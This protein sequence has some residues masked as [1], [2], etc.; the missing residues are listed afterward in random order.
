MFI[1]FLIYCFFNDD[2]TWLLLL[3]YFC[4]FFQVSEIFERLYSCFFVVSISHTGKFRKKIHT[5]PCFPLYF[6]SFFANTRFDLLTFCFLRSCCLQTFCKIYVLKNFCNIQWKTFALDSHLNKVAGLKVCNIV[7]DM[8][9]NTFVTDLAY[10]QPF[11]SCLLI[12]LIIFCFAY[13]FSIP[14]KSVKRN[15]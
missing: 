11:Q 1:T 12:E 4:R 7:C 6:C 8:F 13:L 9:K 14:L 5:L 10:I 2:G 15:M 3:E